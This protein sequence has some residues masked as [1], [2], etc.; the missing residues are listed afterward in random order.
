[1]TIVGLAGSV[2]A[3]A[4]S[5]EGSGITFMP[6]SLTL[7]LYSSLT[8]NFRRARKKKGTDLSITLFQYWGLAFWHRE[9]FRHCVGIPYCRGT[10]ILP[11]RIEGR[12]HTVISPKL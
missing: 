7:T 10:L 8:Q 11:R 2:R 6:P 5:D 12:H 3:S 4:A 1:M 9:A